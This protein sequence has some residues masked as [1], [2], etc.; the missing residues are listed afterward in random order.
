MQGSAL[1]FLPG[2]RTEK[3]YVVRDKSLSMRR[4]EAMAVN[5]NASGR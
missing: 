4:M 5:R 1:D 3:G 2:R